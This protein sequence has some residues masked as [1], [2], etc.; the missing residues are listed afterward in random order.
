MSELQQTAAPIRYCTFCG[1]HQHERK[2]LISGP[3]AFICNECLELC[4]DLEQQ[5]AD[6]VAES[7][8]INR[9]VVAFVLWLNGTPEMWQALLNAT[10]KIMASGNSQMTIGSVFS[11]EVKR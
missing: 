2:L 9:D 6:V 11:V 5:R 10:P 4:M 7:G 8:Y 3:A 1:G